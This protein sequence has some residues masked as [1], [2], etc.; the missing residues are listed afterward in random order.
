MLSF[1]GAI[2]TTTIA[3]YTT[4]LN[5]RLNPNG[6]PITMSFNVYHEFNDY[7]LT[8][9]LYFMGQEINTHSLS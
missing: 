8:H 1:D 6:C 2:T 4:I 3:N 5:N 9:R 7:N